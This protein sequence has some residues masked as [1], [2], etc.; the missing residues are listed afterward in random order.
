MEENLHS[1]NA[2]RTMEIIDVNTGG[3]L[4][5]IKDIKIDYEEQKIISVILPGETKGWFAKSNDVEI[6]W[7]NI[8]KI[9]SDVLLV[10]FDGLEMENIYS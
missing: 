9:G 5:Y 6:P 8:V 2:M 7:R 4:G 10:D 3:K 1:I